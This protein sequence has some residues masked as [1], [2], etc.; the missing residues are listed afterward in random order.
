[1]NWR[2]INNNNNRKVLKGHSGG[3]KSSTWMDVHDKITFDKLSTLTSSRPRLTAAILFWKLNKLMLE[4]VA[5]MPTVGRCLQSRRLGPVQLGLGT[6]AI[7]FT[8]VWR[9]TITK[10]IVRSI[11]KES[12]HRGI[13]EALILY[14]H[15]QAQEHS[16]NWHTRNKMKQHQTEWQNHSQI[17]Q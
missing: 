4:F 9:Q 2:Q 10:R 6:L 17:N 8:W 13:T 5:K 7:F 1:M 16:F 3:Y 12:A 15:W 11:N 14:A